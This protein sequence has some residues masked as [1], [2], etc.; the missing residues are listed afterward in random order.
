MLEKKNIATDIVANA[1]LSKATHEGPVHINDIEINSY[2]LENG[3][4]VLSRIGLL[5][6]IGRTGKAKGGRKYDEEFK[7]PVFLTAKNLKPFISSKLIENST[8]VN[9]TDLHGNKSIGYRAQILADICY[10]FIDALED[11][12]L[13]P[14]QVHIAEQCKILVRGFATTGIIA[15]VD[16]ATGYQYDREHDELQKILKAYI[17]EELL[18]WQKR[19]PDEFYKEIFRLN[20]WGEF[21]VSGL[22]AHQR[23]GVIGTWT[24]RLVYQQ[25]PK[26]VIQELYNK[27]PKTQSGKL[28]KKLHQSLTL[29]MG[30]P[31]LEKQLVSVI[32]LMN[33]SKDWPEFIRFF[34]KKFGQQEIDFA[35]DE[36][37]KLI[38]PQKRPVPVTEFN[39]DLKGLMSVPPPK[40]EPEKST[41]KKKAN[42]D[43]KPE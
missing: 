3:E 32:T 13:L 7:L 40:T 37:R 41:K 23:P 17:S 5:K 42:E 2:V 15:L 22:K 9:F 18:K 28:A 25:L 30:Q 16:E 20:N 27:T 38:E 31:H 8:P 35:S 4:R 1:T 36:Q 24:K 6:A 39:R 43:Q 10:V 34:N 26:G 14:N 33:I 29:D 21:T 12:A 11:N 19:F